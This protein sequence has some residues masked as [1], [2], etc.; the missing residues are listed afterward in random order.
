MTRAVSIGQARQSREWCD[1]LSPSCEN[2]QFYERERA[3]Y[4]VFLLNRKKKF[5]KESKHV[6]IPS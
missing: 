5:I 4:I 6:S 1:W 3:S 2:L